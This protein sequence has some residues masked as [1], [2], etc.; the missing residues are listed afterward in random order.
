MVES[1]YLAGNGSLTYGVEDLDRANLAV[2]CDTIVKTARRPSYMG[3][4][5]ALRGGGGR[6]A[7]RGR[8]GDGDRDREGRSGL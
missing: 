3:A 8:K 6:V 1:G 4:D 7:D 5:V 2:G